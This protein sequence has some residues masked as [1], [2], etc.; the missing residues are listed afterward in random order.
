MMADYPFGD[1]ASVPVPEEVAALEAPPDDGVT[2]YLR[3][4]G[5]TPLLTPQQEHALA[6]D[7][8]A[9]RQ[10]ARRARRHLAARLRQALLERPE[11]R[12]LLQQAAT[13]LA[14]LAGDE[15]SRLAAWGRA[16]VALCAERPP[17]DEAPSDVAAVYGLLVGLARRDEAALA[18]I[19]AT[20]ERARLSSAEVAGF[21][22]R[23]AGHLSL[24]P[25]AQRPDP[26]EWKSGQPEAG[27]S[28]GRVAGEGRQE[29]YVDD[30][31][32]AMSRPGAALL[33]VTA[34]GAGLADT[35]MDAAAHRLLTAGDD[36]VALV[37]PTLHTALDA[38]TVER[39]LA[40]WSVD[41]AAIARGLHARRALAEANLRLV[42]SIAKR[43]A[44]RGL[45]LADLVQEGNLGLLRAVETFDPERGVRFSTYAVWWIRQAII[46]ALA[47][48]SRLVRLPTHLR[49]LQG[50]V[51]RAMRELR[52]TLGREPEA[53][54]VAAA[55]GVPVERVVELAALW[56][57]PLSLDRPVGEDEEAALADLLPD[58]DEESPEEEVDNHL[59]AAQMRAA[60]RSLSDR[61]REVL[62]LRFGLADGREYSLG[63][64]G[65]R[66]GITRERVRQ[67]EAK[68]LRKLRHPVR[69]VLLPPD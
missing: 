10:A 47:D 39:L 55:V 21:V 33:E 26:V 37:R 42:V 23:A 49:E 35:A 64:V 18:Q 4:I 5:R 28:A 9:G 57:E 68:A 36:I 1:M 66:L 2:A 69:R 11:G 19:V 50:R 60:L 14:D 43:Y 17:L 7:V 27:G 24:R 52:A 67:I 54:E 32:L 44:Y 29:L 12:Q 53:A 22:R 15:A 30:R 46:R 56:R 62:A 13:L 59:T 20:A 25:A 63:E 40:G 48:H 41:T 8:Q 65:Q 38:A 31:S 58:E 45:D 51:A 61:E 34:L 16:L 6:R 3:A